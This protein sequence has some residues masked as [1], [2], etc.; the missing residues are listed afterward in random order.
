MV[1]DGTFREDL[2]YRLNVYP[3]FIPPLRFRRE[4]IKLLAAY[5]LK[6]FSRN[7]KKNIRSIDDVSCICSNAA[8]GRVMSVNSRTRWNGWSTS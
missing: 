7:L 3:I 8:I 1:Q 4:D 5:F 6:T 2:F